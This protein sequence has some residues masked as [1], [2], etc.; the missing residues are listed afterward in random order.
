MMLRRWM[1]ILAAL[2]WGGVTALAF[3]AVPVLFARMGNPAVAGPVAALLFE[4]VSKFSV[5]AGLW[6]AW[7]LWRKL[8][9]PLAGIEKA[10]LF[11]VTFAVLAAVL[12]D[13]WVAHQIVTARATGGNLKLWHGMG[14]ALVLVQWLGA[15]CTLWALTGLP[16]QR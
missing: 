12:Q 1:I 7:F 14:S 4:V 13:T 16:S 5:I 6:L 11:L 10:A 15:S 9:I 3:V 2:W 8:A